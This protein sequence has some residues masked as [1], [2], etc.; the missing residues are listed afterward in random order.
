MPTSLAVD[1]GSPVIA[2]EL[3]YD[4]VRTV[5]EEITPAEAALRLELSI[6]PFLSEGN[7]D[8]GPDG[9][10][11]M[12]HNCLWLTTEQPSAAF[13]ARNEWPTFYASLDNLDKTPG[14]SGL[15]DRGP[16]F[17]KGNPYF[18]SLKALYEQE[19]LRIRTQANVSALTLLRLT[20]KR[21]RCGEMTLVD[22]TLSMSST[23]CVS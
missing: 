23:L 6:F 3:E 22:G 15:Q 10:D 8:R 9:L 12:I 7:S 21:G 18:P 4:L 20:D 13:Y 14:Q 16:V 17:S 5:V 1:S 11:H 2:R 19:F